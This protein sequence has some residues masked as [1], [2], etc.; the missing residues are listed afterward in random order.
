MCAHL[1]EYYIYVMYV[2]MHLNASVYM[3]VRVYFCISLFINHPHFLLFC[4]EKCLSLVWKLTNILGWLARNLHGSTC[5]RATSTCLHV[6]LFVLHWFRDST[7]AIMITKETLYRWAI[8]IDLR[9]F[10]N[11]FKTEIS[12]CLFFL[13]IENELK[14]SLIGEMTRENKT[15]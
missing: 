14:Q 2:C 8:A 4:F 1:Y 15:V 11:I 10:S 9:P 5:T 13:L 3:W 6:K 7:Q 12:I